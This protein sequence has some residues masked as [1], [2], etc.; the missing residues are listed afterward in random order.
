[1]R[2]GGQE[3]RADRS[4]ELGLARAQIW[5]V[6]NALTFLRILLVAPFV[7]LYEAGATTAA[8]IV[9]A[10]AALS[11]GL[12]GF[13]A[14][15]LDQTSR[16][17]AMLDPIGD[18]LLCLAA[19]IVLV[20]G[21][22]LPSW[23]LATSLM[24]DGVVL[25]IALVAL[26]RRRATPSEPIKLGKLATLAT[27]LTVI[28]ALALSIWPS[29]AL[30][31]ALRVLCILSAILLGLAALGYAFRALGAM[32]VPGTLPQNEERLPP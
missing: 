10:V 26:A 24:R 29:G 23:L 12:D 21:T 18:K 13:L 16:L 30:E 17:G 19:L 27:N 14:R 1:M 2:M 9:F 4:L 7:L 5:T 15:H 31:A 22:H 28:L 25:S 32:P 20:L 8:A 6:P 11:D 3:R